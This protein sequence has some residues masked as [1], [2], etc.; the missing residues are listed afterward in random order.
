MALQSK[1][2]EPCKGGEDPMGNEEE[3]QM[4][5]QIENW[6]LE[7]DGEHHIHKGFKFNDFRQ[8]MKFVNKVADLANEEA[9]HP[10]LC[11]SYNQVDVTLFTHK[12]GGLHENDFIM[13]SKI[14]HIS[15]V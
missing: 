9:H 11:I 15:G 12:I 14:D 6:S 4:I 5:S 8:A 1:H 13:A 10:D 7:R 2:C 3:N